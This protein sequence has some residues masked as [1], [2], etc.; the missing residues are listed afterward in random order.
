MPATNPYRVCN[1]TMAQNGTGTGTVLLLDTAYYPG[2]SNYF[3]ETVTWNGSNFTIVSTS[4]VDPLGPLPVRSNHGMSFDGGTHIILF[5]GQGGSE[6]AGVL[7]DSWSWNGTTWTKLAPTVVP[8]GRYKHVMTSLFGVGAFMF[9][10]TNVLN[11][12]NESWVYSTSTSNWVQLTPA[13]SPPART[14]CAMAGSTTATSVLL[15]GGK[16]TNSSFGD[17]YV[18]SG[19]LSGNWVKQF[20]AVS[21]PA[22]WGSSIAYDTTNAQWVMFGGASDEGLISPPT[23]YVYSGGTN[24]LGGNWA[25]YVMP[26]GTGPASR[27]GAQMCFDGTGCLLFGG[28]GNSGVDGLTW[29]FNGVSKTWSQL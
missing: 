24:G 1:S 18:F 14:D 9:G 21:P 22:M 25:S 29:R 17:T 5:G 7:E 27:V 2:A 16:G 3:N 20:P 11:I 28:Y 4:Q 10:G 12:L 26:N 19:G 15:F 8:F 13:V 6:T 23:T